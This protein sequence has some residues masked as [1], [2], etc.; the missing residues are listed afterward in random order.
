MNVNANARGNESVIVSANG[1]GNAKGN[2]TAKEIDVT[3]I[4]S[5]VHGVG[6]VVLAEGKRDR[7]RR[8][9]RASLADLSQGAGLPNLKPDPVI[10]RT[11]RAGVD[12]LHR[13]QPVAGA[14]IPARRH[15][16]CRCL[17]SRPVWSK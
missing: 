6:V 1:N 5:V 17:E 16:H 11:G 15:R 12:R 3:G 8:R 13:D 14:L 10:V 7:V 4:G 2:E 9:H